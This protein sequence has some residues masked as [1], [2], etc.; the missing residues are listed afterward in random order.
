MRH[1]VCYQL[2]K[3]NALSC[4]RITV[5]KTGS[6]HK[7]MLGWVWCGR[8]NSTITHFLGEWEQR[9][10][11][12]LLEPPPPH[13][14]VVF[15]HW[16]Y[17]SV[18]TQQNSQESNSSGQ[19][20]LWTEPKLPSIAGDLPGAEVCWWPARVSLASPANSMLVLRTVFTGNGLLKSSLACVAI[21][22]TQ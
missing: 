15:S 18:K 20:A 11:I 21:A 1:F 13:S 3:G 8:L 9:I 5:H 12:A 2:C 22:A 16:S 7:A 14:F 19:S 17:G 4:S 6:I 10:K